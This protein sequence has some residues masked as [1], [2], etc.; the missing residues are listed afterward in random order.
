MIVYNWIDTTRNKISFNSCKK[1]GCNAEI[2]VKKSESF[3]ILLILK[4]NIS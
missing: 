2:L 3:F 1:K 4:S